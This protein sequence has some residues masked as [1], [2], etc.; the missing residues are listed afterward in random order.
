MEVVTAGEHL[1]DADKIRGR[2]PQA[3]DGV[4]GIAV[5]IGD[6]ERK[7]V[8]FASQGPDLFPIQQA[9]R[10]TVGLR[11]TD[12]VARQA[13]H[14]GRPDPDGGEAI[15]TRGARQHERPGVPR[16][17]GTEHASPPSPPARRATQG[18]ADSVRAAHADRIAARSAHTDASPALGPALVPGGRPPG[19][20][21][22]RWA[23]G[24]HARR[25]L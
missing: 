25:R 1:Q 8:A 4:R 20:W 12:D 19:W 24:V 10:D 9:S 5:A 3:I 16:V 13:L 11:E 7:D 6:A 18:T 14:H 23:S 22:A 2:C 17:I 15:E 21:A